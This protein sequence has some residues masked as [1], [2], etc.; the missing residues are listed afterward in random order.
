[1][2]I[3]SKTPL[4]KWTFGPDKDQAKATFRP[5][6]SLDYDVAVQSAVKWFRE[7]VASTET[8]SE[9]GLPQTEVDEVLKEIQAAM[10]DVK[11]YSR[12]L[13]A[14][15]LAVRL[16]SQI[17]NF[18]L[19]G[20]AQTPTRRAFAVLFRDKDILDDWLT[21]AERPFHEVRAAGNV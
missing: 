4:L 17:E 3:T 19:D 7:L 12:F 15:A 6:T 18:T 8:Q 11:A 13:Y 14:V 10:A 1:M 5:M 16:I 20:Q 9:F 21:L 2:D